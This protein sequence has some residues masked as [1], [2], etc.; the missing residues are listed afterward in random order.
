L[1]I[2]EFTTNA[3]GVVIPDG[4]TGDI[5]DFDVTVL[6]SFAGGSTVIKLNARLGDHFT[7]VN[8]GA[9][10]L[11]PAPNDTPF[12][13]ATDDFLGIVKPTP[14]GHSPPESAGGAVPHTGPNP[15]VS[16]LVIHLLTN[17]LVMV[18]SSLPK[19]TRVGHSDGDD[20]QKTT[21]VSVSGG[22]GPNRAQTGAASRKVNDT[23]WQMFRGADADL[24]IDGLDSNPLVRRATAQ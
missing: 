6:N 17:R 9:A 19:A 5:I 22:L 12:N 16:N 21:T 14:F 23:F 15:F 3:N 1:Y 2:S 13:P 4:V 7:D 20:A 10:T 11:S 8:G 18:N 24:M